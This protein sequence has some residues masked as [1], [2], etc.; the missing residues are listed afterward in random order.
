MYIHTY[1]HTNVLWTHR[2]GR[3]S[4]ITVRTLKG[5]RR[6]SFYDYVSDQ[7]PV[8]FYGTWSYRYPYPIGM[9]LGSRAGTRWTR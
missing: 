5:A 3:A 6:I 7:V 9:Y 8:D 1:L 2:W 4:N